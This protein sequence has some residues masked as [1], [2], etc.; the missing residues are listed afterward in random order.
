M[1][2]FKEEL[3]SF[4]AK[5]PEE[6]RTEELSRSQKKDVELAKKRKEYSDLLTQF[7]R[8]NRHFLQVRSFYEYVLLNSEE[9][10]DAH[11]LSFAEDYLKTLDSLATLKSNDLINV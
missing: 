6:L 8:K 10:K 9:W 4:R 2:T 1:E 7:I 3:Q 11:N 5:F